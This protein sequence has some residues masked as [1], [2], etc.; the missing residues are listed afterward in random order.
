MLVLHDHPGSPSML[1]LHYHPVSPY[2]RK[3]LVALLHRGDAFARDVVDVFRGGL[4]D[5]RFRALSPFGRM[6]VLETPEGPIFESTSIVEYLEDRGPRVLL[7]PGEERAARHF[8]RLG[9]LYLI[10]PQSALWFQPGT[11]AAAAAP[12]VIETAW[13]LFEARLAGRDFVCDAGFSLGDVG[14]AIATDY[15]E[16]MGLHPPSI[17]RS[18]RARCFTV[19]AMAEALAEARPVLEDMIVARERRRGATDG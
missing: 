14:A 15:I 3:A 17:V 8:D 18:W 9:D 12:R 4:D 13:G 5:E 16:G 19:P 7:P 1:V 6:P 2:S 11:P 10:E